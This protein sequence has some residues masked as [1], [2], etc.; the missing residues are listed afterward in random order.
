MRPSHPL[1]EAES[2]VDRALSLALAGERDGALRWAAA[3]VAH[4]PA[5]PVALLIAGRMLGEL[6]RKDAALVA[7]AVA[8]ARSIDREN[9]PLAVAAVRELGWFGGPDETGLDRIAEAFCKGAPRRGSLLPLPPPLPPADRFKPLGP[10]IGE[11][12]LDEAAA[13]VTKARDRLVAEPSRPPPSALPLFSS[14][15]RVGLRGLCAAFAPRWLAEGETVIEQGAQGEAAYFVARGELEVRRRRADGERMVLGQLGAGQIFG[16]MALLSR[17]PRTGSVVVT[18]PAIVVEVKR[19]AL[20]ARA[21]LHPDVGVELATHCRDRMVRNLTRMSPV[22]MAVPAADRP[23][24]VARFQPRIF[25]PQE[26][27]IVQGETAPGIYLIALGEVGVVRR[28]PDGGEPLV[29]TTLGP[30]DVAGEVATVLRRLPNADVVAL[31]PTVT[32]FLPAGDFMG[33][34]HEHPAILAELYAIAVR[35]DEETQAAVGEDASDAE[36]AED[37]ALV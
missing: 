23:A 28:D 10:L 24:L 34:L 4:D 8:V 16:E 7:C 21:D 27:L 25:E 12:L 29:L 32:L 14:I 17:A 2:P 26:R 31:H 1:V 6:G 18:R 19:A 20:D 9:L 11:A 30:G 22:L 3:V 35:R 36:D 33:L 5:M 15:G 13:I 37:I